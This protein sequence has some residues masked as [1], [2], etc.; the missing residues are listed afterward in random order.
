[1]ACFLMLKILFY[2]LQRLKLSICLTL[3][4]KKLFIAFIIKK[5]KQENATEKY[6]REDVEGVLSVS[7]A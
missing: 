6:L 7:L 4:L 2:Q 1:M 5:V 3:S